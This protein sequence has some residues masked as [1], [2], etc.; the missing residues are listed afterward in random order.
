MSKLTVTVS[1]R[2]RDCAFET[3]TK[4]PQVNGRSQ[5]SFLEL[6]NKSYWSQDALAV[7]KTGLQKM[8]V[9]VD[10]IA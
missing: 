10:G 7:A 5:S 8:K 1:T 9:L 2:R 3:N 6:F 4:R